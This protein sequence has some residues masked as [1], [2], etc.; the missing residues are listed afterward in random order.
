LELFPLV[1]PLF[2]F[3]PLGLELRSLNQ[4][5][6]VERFLVLWQHVRT[7]HSGEARQDHAPVIK[8]LHANVPQVLI[9]ECDD[10]CQQDEEIFLCVSL[11]HIPSC[12]IFGLKCHY[13]TLVS[14]SMSWL[15]GGSH[16]ARFRT[17]SQKTFRRMT[18]GP[19]AA[20]NRR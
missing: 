15:I 4:R 12:C 14:G 5:L 18:Q 6:K 8:L 3:F 2:Q 7:A 10:V 1:E 11:L 19:L 17:R 13:F 20:E 9:G 16:H